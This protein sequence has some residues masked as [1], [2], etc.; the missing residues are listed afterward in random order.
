MGVTEVQP[1]FT[2]IIGH[3]SVNI[4][5]IST[6]L[7]TEIRFKEPFKCAKFQPNGAPIGVLWQVLQKALIL[8]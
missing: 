1:Y 3:N 8:W 6:K 7:G 5:W 2:Q 4:H